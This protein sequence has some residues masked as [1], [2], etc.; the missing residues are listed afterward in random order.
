[1]L[2]VTKT[3]LVA[4]LNRLRSLFWMADDFESSQLEGWM[5]V[6]QPLTVACSSLNNL[7]SSSLV[8]PNPVRL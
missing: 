4:T 5:V 6:G 8:F 2:L 7:P 1:M 3:G